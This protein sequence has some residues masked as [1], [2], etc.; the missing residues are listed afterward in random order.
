MTTTVMTPLAV[1]VLASQGMLMLVDEFVFHRRRDMPRWE[2][3][4]HPLDTLSVLA[5]L[6]L[7]LFLPAERPWIFV[8]VVLAVF[9]SLLVTKDEGVHSRLC[10]AGEQWLHAVLFLLHPLIF[11]AIW[12]LWRQG[13]G[14]W[15]TLQASLTVGFFVWQFVYWNGPWA[16]TRRRL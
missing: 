9:S 1:A 13:E 8:F 14:V 3:I 4:G 2:R 7:A 12:I 6:L 15:I 10:G 5:P 11:V 16:P